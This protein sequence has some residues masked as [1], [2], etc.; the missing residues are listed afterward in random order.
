MALS[1]LLPSVGRVSYNGFTFPNATISRIQSRPIYD[2]AEQRVKYVHHSLAIECILTYVDNPQGA[3]LNAGQD[4]DVGTNLEF[5]RRKLEEPGK[6]LVFTEQGFGDVIV[7]ATANPTDVSG[8]SGTRFYDVRHGPKPVLMVWEAGGSNRSVRIVW[9]VDCWVVECTA[10]NSA[11]RSTA[12]FLER[13]QEIQWTVS[14]EGMLTRTCR[15][16]HEIYHPKSTVSEVKSADNTVPNQFK[17]E[18]LL[19]FHRDSTRRLS[20]D[21]RTEEITVTDTEIPSDN[22]YFPGM[23]K[24]DA[25]H[26]VRSSLSEGGFARWTNTISVSVRYAAGV[27]PAV[28]FTAITAI[29]RSRFRLNTYQKR[30]HYNKSK[31]NTVPAQNIPVSMSIRESLYDRKI[32]ATLS[33]WSGELFSS[34]N[35][36]SATNLFTAVLGPSWANWHKSLTDHQSLLGFSLNQQ[37]NPIKFTDSCT[38][39]GET[40]INEEVRKAPQWIPVRLF[41][42]SCSDYK[43]ST[44]WIYPG[45]PQIEVI[46][47]T[48][49]LRQSPSY[50]VGESQLITTPTE[51]PS[52]TS[53]YDPRYAD[54]SPSKEYQ[55]Y[56]QHRG[57]NSHMIRITGTIMRVCWEPKAPKFKSYGGV[58]LTLVK[59][60]VK[61]TPVP[62]GMLPIFVLQYDVIYSLPRLPKGNL[63]LELVHDADKGD[64]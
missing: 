8:I 15:F 44:S 4:D 38:G 6:T 23:V 62:G 24:I 29:L 34:N 21:G 26:D 2:S 12:T 60:K 9:T 63:L 17:L 43:P 10:F 5:I 54:A 22:P 37:T 58:P 28:A 41:S 18:P 36:I 7:N 61:L 27:S 31:S 46:T 39:S 19:G 11:G 52:S 16:I 59:S 47:D 30:L 64:R 40:G 13:T 14:P 53:A 1:R 3:T 55:D 33:Y 56:Y 49:V 42:A 45:Y 32:S 57:N 25:D 48:G 35:L 51:S 20:R 50:S